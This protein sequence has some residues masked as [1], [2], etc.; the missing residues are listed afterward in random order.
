VTQVSPEVSNPSRKND[1]SKID[2]IFPDPKIAI[3]RAAFLT[4]VSSGLLC[5]FSVVIALRQMAA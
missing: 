1:C 3:F 5:V 2:P 4:M